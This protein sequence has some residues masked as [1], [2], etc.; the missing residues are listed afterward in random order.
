MLWRGSSYTL[1]CG[2]ALSKGFEH[3][4]AT[5]Q[6]LRELAL[7]QCSDMKYVM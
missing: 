5:R 3:E 4:P 6:G 1:C 7:H 2:T